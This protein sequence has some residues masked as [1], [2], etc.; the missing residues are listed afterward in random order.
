MKQRAKDRK[1]TSFQPNQITWRTSTGATAAAFF[2]MLLPA[3][4][5]HCL[6]KIKPF[7]SI[8]INYIIN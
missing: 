8:F 6:L 2:V 7:I 1:T 5:D 3:A 4:T